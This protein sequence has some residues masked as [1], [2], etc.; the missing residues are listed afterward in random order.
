MSS[1]IATQATVIKGENFDKGAWHAWINNF[2]G[3]P[4]SFHVRGEVWVGNPGVE[5][6]LFTKYPQG[7]N[8]DILL[9]ELV[10]VQKP[11][12]W[13]QVPVLTEAKYD[14]AGRKFTYTEVK[15][16]SDGN[17]IASVPVETI[18]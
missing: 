5:A 13:T 10:L 11:G 18:S 14:R 7:I 4:P 2:P 8:K 6:L 3:G 12:V 9:L 1:P 15:I 17:E 16:L